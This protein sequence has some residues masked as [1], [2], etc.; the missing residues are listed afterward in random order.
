MKLVD[1][2]LLLYA[3]DDTAPLHDAARTWLEQHLSGTETV[4]FAW[5]ALLGFLRLSTNPRVFTSPLTAEAALD[6][7]ETWLAQPS[8]TVLHPTRRHAAVLRDLLAPLGTAG[9][10][11]SDAH[12]AALAVEHGAQV[13]S[14]DDDFA[15]FAGVESV[16]PLRR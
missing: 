2:N 4:G 10:L 5:N 9:N 12:I 6:R 8:A 13:C 11:T 3:V 14:T 16:N 15:R 7:I 1:T